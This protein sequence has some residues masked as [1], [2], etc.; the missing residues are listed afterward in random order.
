MDD[1]LIWAVLAVGVHEVVRFFLGTKRELEP[2]GDHIF[3]QLA[4][5]SRFLRAL[6]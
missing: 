6:P 3:Q 4:A 5:S 2:R 1:L